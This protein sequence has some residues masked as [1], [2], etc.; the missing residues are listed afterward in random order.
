M[1]GNTYKIIPESSAGSTKKLSQKLR[2]L[3]EI[4]DYCSDF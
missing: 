4:L 1:S 2:V 3:L